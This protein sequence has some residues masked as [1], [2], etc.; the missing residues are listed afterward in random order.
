MRIIQAD[1]LFGLVLR[2]GGGKAWGECVYMWACLCAC[3]M[4]GGVAGGRTLTVEPT[5]ASRTTFVNGAVVVF[6]CIR[7]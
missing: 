1:Q 3:V 7:S 2:C 6:D 5:Q 4:Q